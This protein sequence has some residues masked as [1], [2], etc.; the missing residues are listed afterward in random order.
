[1]RP[2]EG[3]R[4][5]DLTHVFAGPFS[6][7]QLGVL[8]AEVIKIEAPGAPDMTRDDGAIADLNDQGMGLFFQAQGGGK[9]ALALDLKAPEGRAVF[10]DL[11]RGADVVVQNYTRPAARRLGL[12]YERLKALNPGLIFCSISGF[13]Q[14]GPKQDHPAYDIVI[15]AFAGVMTSNGTPDTTPVRVGPAMIDYGTGSQAALAISAALYGRQ[16]TGLGR[17]IDVSMADC[18]LMLMN[19]HTKTTLATGTGPRPNGNQDPTLAGYSCYDTAEGQV[20]LG[21]FT[22]RQ[23]VNLMRALGNDSAADEIENTPRSEIGGRRAQD[24]AFL[25]EVLATETAQ[26]WE[27]VLNAHHVPAA[28]VRR[29]EESLNEEQFRSRAVIQDLGGAGFAVAGYSYDHGSPRL[30][31][32]PRPHGADTDAI[33]SDMGL[34]PQQIQTLRNRGVIGAA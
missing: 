6:A 21:A 9:R 19:S 31:A 12:E 8:G 30:D 5:L 20:M 1:M 4:V 32:P 13:G 14:T 23:M 26:H 15:Q 29:L 10:D 16:V 7:Y 28:R 18:A 33:L 27:D 22:N 34:S 25:S 2:F 3:L 24:A 11:V 17:E